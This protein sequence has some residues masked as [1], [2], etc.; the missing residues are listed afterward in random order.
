M[1]LRQLP[2]PSR[3]DPSALAAVLRP[4]DDLSALAARAALDV[5]CDLQRAGIDIKLIPPNLLERLEFAR[6]SWLYLVA[7]NRGPAATAALEDYREVLDDLHYYVEHVAPAP[8]PKAKGARRA[9]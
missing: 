8:T 4:G 7:D 1:N 2:Q 3:I 6:A 5:A 9:H